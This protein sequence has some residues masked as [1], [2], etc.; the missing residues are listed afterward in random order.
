MRITILGCGS[1]NGVPHIGNRWGACDPANPKNR[2]SRPSALVETGGVSFLIDTSPDLREQL[3]LADVTRIDAVLWTHQH[4]D[5]VHGLD[6]LRE[7]CRL[8]ESPIATYALPE[9][10]RDI[11]GRFEYAFRPLPEEHSYYRP[12]LSPH[13]IDGPFDVGGVAVRPFLQDHGWQTSVGYRIGDFAY[14]TDVVRMDDE[15]FDAL[16]GVKV[17]VVDCVR[18]EPHPVHSHLAQSLDWIRRV[19]PERAYFT[20]MGAEMDYDSLMRVLPPG[21][22]PG[23]DGLT[24]DLPD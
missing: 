23:Y 19:K 24:I 7:I 21:V 3:I 6:D 8:M 12:V 9:H 16:D 1:S 22:E 18:I 5:H 10:Q 17:W 20:H 13:L 14:S 11:G 15:A 4:A 2:R